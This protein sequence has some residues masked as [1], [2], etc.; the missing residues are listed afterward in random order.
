[1]ASVLFSTVGQV[2]GGPLGAGIGAAVGASVDAGLFRGR[3]AGAQDGFVSRSAYGETVPRVFGNFR[4]PGLL[5]WATSPQNS[6]EKGQGRRAQATNLALALSRGRVAGIGRI[7]ADGALLRN[8]DGAF[9]TPIRMRLHSQGQSEPDPLILAAE[10]AD[11]APAYSQLSYVVFEDFDLGPF[12]N[13]IPSLSF[14]VLADEAAPAD[15]LGHMASL[16]GAAV[17]PGQRSDQLDGYVANFDTF[18]SDLN[19]LL[20]LLGSRVGQREGRLSFIGVPRLIDLLPSDFLEDPERGQSQ[21]LV[22]S[23]ERPANLGLSYQDSARDYQLGWQQE[24][25]ARRGRALAASWPV[26]AQGSA[27][28]AIAMR[29]L[30]TAEAG[31]DSIRFG[32]PPRFMSLSVGDAVRLGDGSRWLVVGREIRGLS[33]WVEGRR[34]PDT[35]PGASSPTDAGRLLPSPGIVVPPTVAVVLEPPV[36]LQAGATPSLLIIG[37]GQ[38]GWMG[39]EVQSLS[40]GEALSVG[41]IDEQLPFGILAEALPTSPETVWDK[42]NTILIDTANGLDGFLSRSAQDVLNGGGLISVGQE[43]VQ[44]CTADLIGQNL[45]RLSGLLRGRF[46][47]GMSGTV[48][49][50]GTVVM[51][52]P[53]SGGAKVDLS[54]D[55]PGRTVSLLV[56]GVGD[57]MGGAEV[58]HQLRGSG[59]APFAPVHVRGQR[60]DDGTI[61]CS[62]VPRSREGWAWGDPAEFRQGVLLWHFLNSE[63]QLWTIPATSHGIELSPARQGARF[64][65]VLP[66]GRFCVEA[67]GEGPAS[68]RSTPFLEI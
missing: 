18:S 21:G 66:Q 29:L 44:Y 52:A 55:S 47:T 32:L 5:I 15:W 51:T 65:S 30:R 50:A 36:A 19:G 26:A 2:I 59:Y 38:A 60:L 64:G 4:V 1:M 8:A 22:T 25:L 68:L 20:T 6:G 41:R 24:V 56:S 40:G 45:V 35:E 7:W 53:R 13:R 37:S 16:V 33:V 12:G 48:H 43:L 31:S 27:A 39:A 11:Q 23:S 58:R 14:E 9:L 54:P 63:G 49:P 10:G 42:R 17:F 3:R 67:V 46:A 34:M 62:W 61:I 28:R 57:V